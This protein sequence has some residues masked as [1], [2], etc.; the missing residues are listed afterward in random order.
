MIVL[1]G[2][3]GSKSRSRESHFHIPYVCVCLYTFLKIRSRL[4]KNGS[5]SLFSN[6]KDGESFK[7]RNLS[8]SRHCATV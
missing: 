1:R 4:F 3:V 6:L 2:Q 5:K 8:I 7:S